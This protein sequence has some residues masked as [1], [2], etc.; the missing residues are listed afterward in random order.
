MSGEKRT[1]YFQEENT[2]GVVRKVVAVLL[3]LVLCAALMA[4]P[5]SAAQANQDGLRV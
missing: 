1:I 5:A 2:M 3:A 4:V